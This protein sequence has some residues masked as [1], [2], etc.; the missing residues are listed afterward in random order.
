MHDNVL[1]S[2]CV[3][4]CFAFR[5]DYGHSVF[6]QL[7]FNYLVANSDFHFLLRLIS[8]KAAAAIATS[9]DIV[10]P[11]EPWVSDWAGAENVLPNR[12]DGAGA[13]NVMA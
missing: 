4:N 7:G 5:L 8:R 13:N 11:G 12:T 10:G 2:I 3:L 6:V 9:A 1:R